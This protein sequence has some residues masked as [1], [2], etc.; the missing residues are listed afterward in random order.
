MSSWCQGP[1]LGFDT[2]TT[3]IDVVTDRI[4]TA[5]LVHRHGPRTTVRTWLI[6]PG[7]EIPAAASAVHGISTSWSRTNGA[8][9]A[10]ALAQVAAEITAAQRAGT[11]L[12]AYNAAFDLALLDRE[13]DRHGL[14]TLTDRLGGPCPHVIDPLVLDRALDPDREGTRRLTDLC[15]HYQVPA[16]HL[17]TADADV[18]ATLDV[19]A[20]ITARF[21]TLAEQELPALHRW[22]AAQ[23]R[24]WAEGYNAGRRADRPAV[25][26]RW[27]TPGTGPAAD[28]DRPLPAVGPSAADPGRPMPAARPARAPL[29]V[30]AG[31]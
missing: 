23:H 31:A 30:A 5:A 29:P 17:H 19:L 12:V 16:R 26:P 11:P 14:P 13:L 4:V 2:E 9:P 6:D 22:Q 15:Q 21:P 7:V 8:P 24:A 3:G 18:V 28:P 20:R 10:A 1:F 27:P 25:D